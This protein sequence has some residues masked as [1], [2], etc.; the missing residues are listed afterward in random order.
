MKNVERV[1]NVCLIASLEH[2]FTN[3]SKEKQNKKWHILKVKIPNE[4][5]FISLKA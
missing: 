2:S 5:T 1:V 3:R 4:V